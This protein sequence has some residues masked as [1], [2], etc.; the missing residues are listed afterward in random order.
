MSTYAT[1][2]ASTGVGWNNNSKL[3]TAT[4]QLYGIDPMIMR[5]MGQ[6]ESGLNPTAKNPYGS[7]SGLFQVTDATWNGLMKR[8]AKQLGIP[9]GTRQTDA[10]ANALLSSALVNEHMANIKKNGGS[11][12][13]TDIYMNHFLGH[14]GYSKFIKTLQKNPNAS[15]ASIL[16]PAQIQH[17]KIYTMSNGKVATVQQMYN[18]LAKK[19]GGALDERHYPA[20][21]VNTP[22]TAYTPLPSGSASNIDTST[23]RQMYGNLSGLGF[24]QTLQP[25]TTSLG[26][27][28]VNQGG[29]EDFT[30]PSSSFTPFYD[31]Y[32]PTIDPTQYKPLYSQ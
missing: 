3:I 26:L 21:N 10:R 9:A 1:L 16:T 27:P 29:Y 22:S 13:P 24:G 5:K 8:Y 14:G 7:A 20:S 25:T 6:A 30:T 17:N 19:M 31:G 23:L 15:V 12:S 28:S 11:V 4:S 2:P 32:T 18:A